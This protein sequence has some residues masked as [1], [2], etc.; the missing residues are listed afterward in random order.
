MPG[1]AMRFFTDADIPA[2]VPGGK[3]G[4]VFVPTPANQGGGGGGG[5]ALGDL[6]ANNYILG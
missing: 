5:S 6:S 3:Q 4:G 1:V 2:N